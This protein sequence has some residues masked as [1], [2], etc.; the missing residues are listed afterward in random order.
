M[1]YFRYFP[2][3]PYKLETGNSEF[4]V[5]LTQITSHAQIVEKLQQNVTIIYDYIIDG[6]E[7]PDNVAERLYGDPK[8]TW[9]LLVLNN[10]MSLFDWPKNSADFQDYIVTKYG[11]I[12]DAQSQFV[13]RTSEGFL[14]D[15][16]TFDGLLASER[17][18]TTSA[19]D[20]EITTN[21]NRRRIRI[22]PA[23]FVPLLQ[24][25]LAKLFS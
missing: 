19:Y 23:Q 1:N 15:K 3:S 6:E 11:S 22:V 4:D 20:E 8:Y 24:K 10:L 5:V 13:Y 17:G 14:V 12:E 25:E 9:I 2:S 18:I 7:R 21:D 16:I